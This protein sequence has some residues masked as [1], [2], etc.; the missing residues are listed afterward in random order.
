MYNKKTY[1]QI[2]KEPMSTQ[3]SFFIHNYGKLLK[4]V[5]FAHWKRLLQ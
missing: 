3:V 2:K 1:K 4:T 5:Y